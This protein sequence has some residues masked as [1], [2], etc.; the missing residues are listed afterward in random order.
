[1]RLPFT[2]SGS[3]NSEV[4]AAAVEGSASVPASAG[5]ESTA[6]APRPGRMVRKSIGLPSKSGARLA[7]W[8][9]FGSTS[10]RASGVNGEVFFRPAFRRAPSP[11]VEVVFLVVYGGTPAGPERPRRTL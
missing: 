4:S 10:L 5:R 11:R 3:P 7:L 1:M 8:G 6:R 9:Q 2:K